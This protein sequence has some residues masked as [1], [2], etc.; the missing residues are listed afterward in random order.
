MIIDDRIKIQGQI[1]IR[2]PLER[3]GKVLGFILKIVVILVKK[4]DGQE[5]EGLSACSAAT[6]SDGVVAVGTRTEGGDVLLGDASAEND[7]ESPGVRNPV[8][9]PGA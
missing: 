4:L 8:V 6:R 2:R 9:A 1:V 3:T 5:I 7:P